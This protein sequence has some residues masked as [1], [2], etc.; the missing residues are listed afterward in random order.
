MVLYFAVV[1]ILILRS[2]NK[3]ILESRDIA[4][5]KRISTNNRS[6]ILVGE[7]KKLTDIKYMPQCWRVRSYE[8]KCNRIR[9]HSCFT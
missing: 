2:F 5:N 6:Y 8:E 4:V 7:R 9:G 1:F 3:H